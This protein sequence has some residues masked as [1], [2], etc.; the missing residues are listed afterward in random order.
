MDARWLAA[1]ALGAVLSGGA[2]CRPTDACAETGTACGGDP[3]GSWTLV[4]ACQDPALVDT[5]VAKR[6][7][8]GQPLVTAGQPP[9]EPTSSDWCADL[10][11]GANGIDFLN[12]PRDPPRLSGGYISYQAQDGLDAGGTY[13]ALWTTDDTTSIDFSASCIQ[14]FGYAPA[15]DQFAVA[16]ATFGTTL[17]GVKNT[18]CADDGSGGCRC[19]YTIEADAAGTN[20]SGQWSAQGGT[21]THFATN[22]LLP[23]QVDYCVRGNEMTLWGHDRTAIMGLPGVRTVSLLRIVCG[24]GR[25]D[26]GEACDPPDGTT[27]NS[28]C[29]L[30]TP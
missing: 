25:V 17:G 26:R 3:V 16:F 28:T 22:M 8:R 20:L 19:A 18:S 2:A 23:T 11:Y 10:V 24:D 14:R 15:C 12:L 27:C 29:Q 4:D 9:P 7:Y 21:I 6:T 1:A 13:G 30:I 5:A